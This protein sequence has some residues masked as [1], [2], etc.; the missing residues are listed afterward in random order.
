MIFRKNTYDFKFKKLTAFLTVFILLIGL[1][2]SQKALALNAGSGSK[3]L[4]FIGYRVTDN[5]TIN[6]WVDKSSSEDPDAFKN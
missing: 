4:N 6:I 5:Y 3:D 2:F 1:T